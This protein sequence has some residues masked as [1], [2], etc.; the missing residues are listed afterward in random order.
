MYF[1]GAFINWEYELHK[2]PLSQWRAV[3]RWTWA[4][5]CRHRETF[6][7][8]CCTGMYFA[9]TNSWFQSINIRCYSGA[10]PV[11][12]PAHQILSGWAL[13]ALH[14]WRRCTSFF[15]IAA[16]W[17]AVGCALQFKSHHVNMER[18]ER[19]LRPACERRFHY[20]DKS[21]YYY[22]NHDLTS[23]TNRFLATIHS[24]GNYQTVLESDGKVCTVTITV[25]SVQDSLDLLHITH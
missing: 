11:L 10:E 18:L 12:V 15:F 25:C 21:V 4:A 8:T 20:S 14:G 19:R 3:F 22:S 2:Q 13:T 17:D 1:V 16:V 9:G 5:A 7:D 24:I 6:N 23:T